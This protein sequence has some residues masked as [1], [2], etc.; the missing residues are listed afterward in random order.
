MSSPHSQQPASALPTS[1]MASVH[2]LITYFLKVLF[3]ITLV[4]Q[5]IST[6]HAVC[7][8]LLLIFLFLSPEFKSKCSF[9]WNEN[10]VWFVSAV[11][12]KRD[13]MMDCRLDIPVV[14]TYEGL[15]WTNWIPLDWQILWR[16]VC[17]P[18]ISRHRKNRVYIRH[19]GVQDKRW[20]RFVSSCIGF[21]TSIWSQNQ[22]LSSLILHRFNQNKHPEIPTQPLGLFLLTEEWKHANKIIILYIPFLSIARIRNEWICVLISPHICSLFGAPLIPWSGLQSRGRVN[23]DVNCDRMYQFHE[24]N[25]IFKRWQSFI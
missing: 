6:L 12:A 10:D 1:Q 11:A 21:I 4:C 17:L 13:V 20:I 2:T 3:I 19:T 25:P 14:K 15:N 8:K 23:V 9:G 24:A 5:A 16:S 7:Q 18:V 22:I